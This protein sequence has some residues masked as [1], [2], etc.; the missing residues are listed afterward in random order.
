M[1]RLLAL[2]SGGKDSTLAVEKALRAGH[3]VACLVTVRPRN[4]THGCFTQYVSQP[5]RCRQKR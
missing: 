3:E 1:V 2:Y 4:S 5:L